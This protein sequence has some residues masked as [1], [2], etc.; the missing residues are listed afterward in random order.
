MFHY[1]TA[2][3]TTSGNEGL[4]MWHIIIIVVSVASVLIG[5]GVIA[6]HNLKKKFMAHDIIIKSLAF[7][8]LVVILIAKRMPPTTKRKKQLQ[9][10]LKNAWSEKRAKITA[11]SSLTDEGDVTDMSVL[12]NMPGEALDTDDEN[13][14]PSFDLETSLS[15][16]HEYFVEKFCE[17]QLDRDDKVSLGLFLTFQLSRHLGLGKTKSAALA[18]IM[19]SRSDNHRVESLLLK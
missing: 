6:N 3:N 4:K 18:G 7:T 15:S 11:E 9:E 1:F 17:L 12:L 13:V 10:Y 14:D 5:A 19:I 16:D 8:A 2:T